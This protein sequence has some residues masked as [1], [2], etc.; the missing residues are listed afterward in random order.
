MKQ[1][2][3]GALLAAAVGTWL[4]WFSTYIRLDMEEK[5]L[6]EACKGQY[7]Y[8]DDRVRACYNKAIIRS[9]GMR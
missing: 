4:V 3:V 1:L 8:S 2:F 9:E 7:E 6:W 5:A